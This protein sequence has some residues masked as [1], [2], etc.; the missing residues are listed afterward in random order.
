[1]LQNIR[2]N[3]QGTMAKV[4]IGIIIV[5]FALFGIESIF[6]GGGAGT[7]AA[8]KVN[9]EEISEH[10]LQRAIAVQKQQLLS[11][12]GENFDPDTINDDLIRGPALD[13][14]IKQELIVQAAKEENLSV[15]EQ[16]LNTNIVESTYFQTEGVFDA[17]RYRDVLAGSGLTPTT[18][19]SLLRKEHLT[20]QIVSGLA[21]SGFVTP[22]EIELAASLSQQSRD[23]EYLVIDVPAIEEKVEF[24]D[25]DINAYFNERKAS[26]QTTEQ[27]NL[28]YLELDKD[29][30][31]NEIDI[32]EDA[33][34]EQ[35]QL[36]V[37][38]F[39]A[40]ERRRVSHILLESTDDA[41][42]DKIKA[43]QARLDAGEDFA[44]L[45]EE[46]SEDVGSKANGGDLG[47]TEGDAF[48]EDFETGIR[49]LAVDQVAL[50]ETDAG[51]HLVKLT[52]YSKTE[53]PT[54]EESKLRIEI[55]LKRV[56]VEN[57]F[58]E[59]MEQLSEL[60][61][62]AEDLAGP[63]EELQMELQETGL[64]A[65]GSGVGIAANSK[66][67][68]EAFTSEALAEGNNSDVIELTTGHVVVVRIKEHK[69]PRQQQLEEVKDKVVAAV[70]QQK[71]K[72]IVED[73]VE[74]AI[75][76]LHQGKTIA[77]VA[78]AEG[79]RKAVGNEVKRMDT[80]SEREVVEK[81]FEM[82]KPADEPIIDRITMRNSN[83]AVIQLTAVKE[84]SV[85][86][87][88]TNEKQGLERYLASTLGRSDY[89]AYEAW[90]KQSAEVEKL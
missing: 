20:K 70:K 56:E 27:I 10:D 34:R 64:F 84:G 63:A 31:V 73:K 29:K 9:G 48:P 87:M 50:V 47:F 65:R 4:I 72:A 55:E 32:D 38:S 30:M 68:N 26:F 21:S 13:N 74:A 41:A 33:V 75:Q 66:V 46:L 69:K 77:E 57:I 90:L 51:L 43:I 8:A 14:L 2:N 1:M 3:I 22:K 16:R 83:V 79:Y 49:D 53:I 5:P 19:L 25:E 89:E 35:Y 6:S 62:N 86:D 40:K 76:Q 58:V 39:E 11:Q 78:E 42:R 12:M 52:E 82:P 80:N 59:K 15:S 81:V 61:F 67:S 24:S 7:N 28:A 18:Y 44:A 23:F 45:A 60:T 17:D 85:D 36:E 54:Y 88:S 71:A 37:E